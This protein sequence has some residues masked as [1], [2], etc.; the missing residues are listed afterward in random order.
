MKKK[1]MN[2]LYAFFN[3]IYATTACIRI[4]GTTKYLILIVNQAFNNAQNGDIS[5]RTVQSLRPK[6]LS[7]RTL[8]PAPN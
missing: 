1:K 8:L 6:K 2:V 5:T 4:S 3:F 7:F